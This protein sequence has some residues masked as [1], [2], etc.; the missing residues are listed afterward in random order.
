MIV[1]ATFNNHPIPDAFVRVANLRYR[2]AA[3]ITQFGLGRSLVLFS[4][5]FYHRGMFEAKVK[6]S[7]LY[8]IRNCVAVW[9]LSAVRTTKRLNRSCEAT[10]KSSLTISARPDGVGAVFQPWIVMGEQSWI[11][12]ARRGDGK[13]FIARSDEKLT[14]FLELERAVCLHLLTE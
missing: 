1:K 6:R 12:D 9:A 13:R 10:E 5:A 14:A 7:S 3:D 4:I 8:R 2:S 11:V